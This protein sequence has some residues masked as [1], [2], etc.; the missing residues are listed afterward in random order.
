MRRRSQ[1]ARGRLWGR[2]SPFR[3]EGGKVWNRRT[4]AVATIRRTSALR[5]CASV[6]SG[7]RRHADV[8]RMHQAS[9]LVKGIFDEL[10]S[11]LL[12]DLLRRT[13]VW[14]MPGIDSTRE[15][16]RQEEF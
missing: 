10:E 8:G 6:W 7:C 9:G 2:T 12:K 4:A 13:I 16:H 14:V 11:E 1:P 15:N 3:G 5:R